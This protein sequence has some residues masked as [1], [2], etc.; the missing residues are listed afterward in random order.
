MT[1]QQTPSEPESDDREDDTEDA[2]QPKGQDKS[3]PP[4]TMETKPQTKSGK[5]ETK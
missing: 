1:E 2:D 5:S 3:W 4:K